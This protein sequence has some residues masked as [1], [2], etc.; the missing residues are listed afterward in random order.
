MKK[1]YTIQNSPKALGPYSQVV[2]SNGF[3]YFSGQLGIDP[4]TGELV[5]GG[6]EKE[7][8]QAMNNI[9]N[10]LKEL[11]LDFSNIVKTTIFLTSMKDFSKVNEIYG[12]YFEKDFPARSSLEVSALAKNASIEIEIIANK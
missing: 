12:K 3:Y 1:T 7:T 6:I 4:K 9:S 10:A 11:N 2:E 8:E 5:V